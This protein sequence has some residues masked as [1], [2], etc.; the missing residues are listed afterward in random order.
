[1][2]CQIICPNLLCRKFLTVPDDT[3]GKAVKCQHC[4]Q[5][6]KVPEEKRAAAATAAKTPAK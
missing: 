6:F 4:G 3:R 1:M 2:P 5:M